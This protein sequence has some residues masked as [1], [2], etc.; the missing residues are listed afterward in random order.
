MLDQIAQATGHTL[1]Q[2]ALNWLIAKPGVITIPKSDHI[3]RVEEN[4]G[5]AGWH[6]S[7]DQVR[8]LD[9]AFNPSQ[10]DDE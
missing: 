6:L 1:A 5:A 3:E 8:A 4:C 9:E 10:D 7:E 2:V